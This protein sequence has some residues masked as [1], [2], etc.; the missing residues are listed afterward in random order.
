MKKQ[1]S[2]AKFLAA[3][4]LS[5]ILVSPAAAAGFWD[6][7]NNFFKQGYDS[8]KNVILAVAVLIGIILVINGIIGLRKSKQ[9]G[10]DVT[11]SVA[12][13]IG[14]LVLVAF[15]AILIASGLLPDS[16]VYTDTNLAW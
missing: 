3:S 2:K 14:G 4:A 8:V 13:I 1:V 12:K 10:G 5:F 16:Q 11:M 15:G 7:F 6:T 9:E